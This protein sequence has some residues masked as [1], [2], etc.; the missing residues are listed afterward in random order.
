MWALFVPVYAATLVLFFV[1]TR[2]RLP[3][4]V[5]LAAA[6]GASLA[7]L[8]ERMKLRRFRQAAAGASALTVLFAITNWPLGVP[9]GRMFQREEQVVWLLGESRVDEALNLYEE[10]EPH[11]PNQ[12][13]LQYRIGL[14]LLD[15]DRAADSVRLLERALKARPDEIRIRFNLGQAL[16]QAGR[17][18]DALP[19]FEATRAAG[20]EPASTFALAQTHASLGDLEGARQELRSIPPVAGQSAEDL[21]RYG[22]L[23]LKLQDLEAAEA[24]LQEAGKRDP[25]LAPV[26]EH[27]GVVLGLR[28]R[29]AE[30]AEAFKEAIAL[31]PGN[32]TAYF[33]LAVAYA[34]MGR[35]PEA[36][37]SAV[38]ALRL[39]PD[40]REA[41]NLL[42]RLPP[43]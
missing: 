41:K 13:A 27:L 33:H 6:S 4:L 26:Q 40:Y 19:H 32:A 18:V 35:F 5:P 7:W 17:F 23:A 37:A 29:P 8:W 21:L 20:L 31:A 14:L 43:G 39:Q 24:F 2:Y 12:S 42:S 28:G 38:E 3:L 1:S 16:L 11:H 34:Q 30:A 10:T 15:R 9:D 36:R 22:A 25:R